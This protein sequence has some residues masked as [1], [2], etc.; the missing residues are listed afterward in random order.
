MA[1]KFGGEF[2]VRGHDKPR[3]VGVACHLLSR[4]YKSKNQG[5]CV[6]QVLCVLYLCFFV[7]FNAFLNFFLSILQGLCAKVILDVGINRVD[8]TSKP[9][10]YRLTGDVH[11]PSAER[12]ASLITPV[13]GGVG[14]MTVAMLMRNTVT[15]AERAI[16]LVAP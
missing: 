9:R 5:I 14:P 13:P 6:K 1:P 10:G 16:E 15:L 4:W 7:F 11:F 8:D 12:K 3:Q 2:F